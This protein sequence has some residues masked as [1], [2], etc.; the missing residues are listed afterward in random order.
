MRRI[1]K[2]ILFINISLFAAF[3]SA[4]GACVISS[5][6]EVLNQR[7]DNTMCYSN[8]KQS[9]EDFRQFC[10]EMAASTPGSTLDMNLEQC[11]KDALAICKGAFG[12]DHDYYYYN[13][14]DG[15][16]ISLV[17]NICSGEDGKFVR[18]KDTDKPN[19]L[20][21]PVVKILA[22]QCKAAQSKRGAT[23]SQS[24]EICDCHI[25]AFEKYEDVVGQLM[26]HGAKGIEQGLIDP[27]RASGYTSLRSQ[28]DAI[29]A[30]NK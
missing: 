16:Y 25:G 4:Q 14:P 11:P 27:K 12:G 2:I 8:V 26:E 3:A 19:T 21:N 1:L 18:L 28:C 6:L 17:K 5:S 22:S 7:I 13:D 24:K 9:K 20:N 15:S 30:L 29:Y 10:Q 23:D